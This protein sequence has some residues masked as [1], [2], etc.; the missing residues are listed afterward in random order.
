MRHKEA[1]KMN[2]TSQTANKLEIDDEKFILNQWAMYGSDGY[3]IRK[4]KSR[5]IWE[6]RG[7]KCGS[8]FK[9]KCEASASWEKFIDVLIERKAGRT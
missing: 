3:P 5:W 1:T 7:F 9:T 8:T 4:L 2:A 6:Q